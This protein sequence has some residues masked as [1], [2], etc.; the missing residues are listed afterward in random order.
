MLAQRFL[1]ASVCLR[2]RL[3]QTRLRLGRARVLPLAAT[4]TSTAAAAA[5]FA[6]YTRRLR[7]YD[8]LDFPE[9]APPDVRK[10]L[11]GTNPFAAQIRRVESG[12]LGDDGRPEGRPKTTPVRRSRK[13][14]KLKEWSAPLKRQY[15][16]EDSEVL[17]LRDV[18]EAPKD[19][20]EDAP[21]EEN[22]VETGRRGEIRRELEASIAGQLGVP[23]QDEVN[24]QINKIKPVS[25]EGP[26]YPA[27]VTRKEL[28]DI[29]KALKDGYNVAQLR[30]Y[31]AVAEGIEMLKEL[32]RGEELESGFK[33]KSV[34]QEGISPIERRLPQPETTKV[35]VEKLRK[36]KVVDRIVRGIWDVGV[37]EENEAIGEIEVQLEPWQFD[38]ILNTDRQSSSYTILDNIGHQ[39]RVRVESYRP[40]SI[41]RFIAERENVEQAITDLE[42]A[43]RRFNALEFDLSHFRSLCEKRGHEKLM[44]FFSKKDLDVTAR[45]SG[46]VL[47]SSSGS[48]LKIYGTERASVELARRI[49]FSIIG[50]P[51]SAETSILADAEG[52]AFI[53]TSASE[54]ALHYRH[55]RKNYGRWT[56]PVTRNS[57]RSQAGTSEAT[58]ES[59]ES[60]GE[61]SANQED[62]A[63]SGD[64]AK[65]TTETQAAAQ[66]PETQSE[67]KGAEK[68]SELVANITDYLKSSTGSPSGA[69]EGEYPASKDARSTYWGPHS[70]VELY[71]SYGNV[72]HKPPPASST[73]TPISLEG[74]L[75]HSDK[76]SRT[77]LH[78]IPGFSPLLQY[79]AAHTKFQRHFNDEKYPD[80]L[81]FR[82]SPA[83]WDLAD[84]SSPEDFPDLGL[85]LM[86]GKNGGRARFQGLG[87]TIRERNIDLLLPEKAVDVRFVRREVLWTRDALAR[88]EDVRNYLAMI[89]M[90]LGGGGAIRAPAELRLR[91]PAWAVKNSEKYSSLP[92]VET[93]HGKEFVKEFIFT[94]VEHRQMVKFDLPGDKHRISYTSVEAGRVGGRR[95][96]LRLRL[97]KPAKDTEELKDEVQG[98]VEGAFDVASLIDDAVHDKLPNPEL[99]IKKIAR[100]ASFMRLMP[101]GRLVEPLQ[102]NTIKEVEDEEVESGDRVEN[103]AAS[104]GETEQAT[105]KGDQAVS[106]V[107]DSDAPL[108]EGAN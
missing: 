84:A 23:G 59:R 64:A 88:S 69:P 13:G 38:L 3:N 107:E 4:S 104:G 30:R 31:A 48:K 26:Q 79:V 58:T 99:K 63:A 22:P 94:A 10:E 6:S 72:I 100:H 67:S 108:K 35:P 73:L 52:E 45:L 85:R 41:L 56:S 14:R 8:P 71:A 76:P 17:I 77:F 36:M 7:T 98:L 81:L 44:D 2:C 95:G 29:R 16:G 61:Q 46:T 80:A 68:A 93:E 49:L 19:S 75:N 12:P 18:F 34:W 43:I 50:P 53:Q 25:V 55:R 78:A 28:A 103:E 74:L 92:S 32:R 54:S 82:F 89:N 9:F 101:D 21:A 90:N 5:S 60:S 15:L 57:S 87:M 11:D 20:A 65:V 47:D 70:L 39:R 106:H 1:G 86:V 24:E 33:W 66:I 102:Y 40:D 37:I 51:T 83:P 96:E 97:R 91:I 62:Q 42:R 27:F 105:S